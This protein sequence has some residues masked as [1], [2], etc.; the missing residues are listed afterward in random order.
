MMINVQINDRYFV[1]DV[2]NT[3]KELLPYN[4]EGHSVLVRHRHELTA[5][6]G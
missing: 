6:E 1:R 4:G 3:S 5:L 2:M